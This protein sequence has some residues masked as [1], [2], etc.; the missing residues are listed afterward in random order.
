M[1][2]TE[3]EEKRKKAGR[4]VYVLVLKLTGDQ[5]RGSLLQ[6]KSIVAVK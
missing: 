2:H 4:H 5:M 1:K 3:L 6:K